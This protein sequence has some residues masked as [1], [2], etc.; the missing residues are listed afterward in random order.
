M[1]FLNPAPASFLPV[2]LYAFM[3]GFVLHR[4]AIDPKRVNSYVSPWA[5]WASVSWIS[6]AEHIQ[7]CHLKFF[8]LVQCLSPTML[9]TCLVWT[10]SP[11]CLAFYLI[12]WWAISNSSLTCYWFQQFYWML[13][14]LVLLL[15]EFC[16]VFHLQIIM[17]WIS[18][19]FL[20]CGA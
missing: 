16:Q 11:D 10:F 2:Y 7:K 18:D 12:M 20:H 15:S 9:H 5:K 4:H 17:I 19:A 14:F 13:V 6:V 1:Q 3:R 8:H